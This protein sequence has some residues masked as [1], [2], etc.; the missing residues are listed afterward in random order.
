MIHYILQVL[1]F[2][3]LFLLV[4]DLFLKKETY[5][6][7]NRL[8]LLATPVLALFIPFLKMEFL[9]E[10][11]PQ[12]TGILLPEVFLGKKP[13]SEIGTQAA[14]QINSGLEINWW[15]LSYFA[16]FAVNCFLFLKKYQSLNRLFRFRKIT[17]EKD[18]KIIEVPNSNIACTFLNTIFLGDQLSEIERS[19][20]LS[21]E[22]VHV[23]QKHSLDL[24]FFE[25][26]RI[27][28][29][30]NPLIYIYQARIA[31]L[32][33]FI[34]DDEVIKTTDRQSYYQQLLNTAFNTQ[35]ISFTNQFYSHSLIKKRILM[36]QKNKSSQLSK[37]KF[38]LLVPAILV[39]LTYVACS[40]SQQADSEEETIHETTNENSE[41]LDQTLNEL[42]KINEEQEKSQQYAYAEIDKAPAF[43][44]CENLNGDARRN[45]TTRK[46]SAYVGENFDS[47]LGKKAGL[48]GTNRVIVEFKIDEKG[49]IVDVT[50]KAAHT[51]LEEEAKRVISS[52][53][54]MQP[55]IHNGNPVSV[56]YALPIVFKI[57][58]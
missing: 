5:F 2:Q 19:Q 55:G 31:G 54:Q 16:G 49:N 35:N 57:D 53:P 34:A 45:C 10:A 56:K 15:Y 37:F 8:Y 42:K 47:S 14:M 27:V 58:E 18:F 51:S 40:D 3:L 11:I 52:L 12:N 32:H 30:F 13:S 38:L 43:T 4:Y 39:M 48:T 25:M 6:N 41:D 17:E 50:S 22:V 21:H 33:E 20:I 44:G 9:A 1:F 7:Y 29:W 28:F 36:S 26:M 23:K 24:L 46:I